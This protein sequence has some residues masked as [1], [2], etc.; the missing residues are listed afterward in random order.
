VHGTNLVF[1]ER[2]IEFLRKEKENGKYII[3]VTNRAGIAKGEFGEEES[4]KTTEYV[5]D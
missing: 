3:I 1:I 2:T 4:V 5:I